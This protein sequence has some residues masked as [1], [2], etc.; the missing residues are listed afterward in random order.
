LVLATVASGQV[1]WGTS[2]YVGWRNFI[3][4]SDPGPGT[5][6]GT[7][8]SMRFTAGKN[9]TVNSAKLDFSI[10]KDATAT[11]IVGIY[12]D[13]G[14]GNPGAL[15][16]APS[17]AVALGV[18]N[19][20]FTLGGAANLVAGNVYHVR[21]SCAFASTT[22]K[23]RMT[24]RPNKQDYDQQGLSGRQVID[25]NLAGLYWEGDDPNIA[26][27][28]YEGK[29][30]EPSKVWDPCFGLYSDQAGTVAAY[31]V[32][33]DKTNYERA[34]TFGQ[35]F[36]LQNVPAAYV[37]ANNQVEVARVGVGL[38]TVKNNP[39]TLRV[40]IRDAANNL[41]T[42]GKLAQGSV[43][44]KT[45]CEVD[46]AH[47]KLTVGQRYSIL[48]YGKTEGGQDYYGHM[49]K[50]YPNSVPVEYSFQGTSSWGIEKGVVSPNS[51]FFAQLYV[52]EPATMCLLAIGG[53]SVLLRKRR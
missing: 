3:Q 11:G 53:V 2:D 47:V 17:A 4:M 18:N 5:A 37:D 43:V 1:W 49:E 26:P 10:A 19:P 34:G 24:M 33:H 50:L 31:G 7:E 52:P 12:A 48:S 46:V 32:G 22:S 45:R 35:S 6:I 28:W 13:D 42:V 25:N 15:L 30:G 21:L 41:L 8:W 38:T 29:P 9:M 36:I 16:G 40:E 39:G 44:T 20:L 27:G 51:Q 23:V 14:S